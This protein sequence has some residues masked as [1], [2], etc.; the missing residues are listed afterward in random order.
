MFPQRYNPQMMVE[1]YAGDT[2]SSLWLEYY[3]LA[4][5]A[6]GTNDDLAII[7]QLPLYLAESVRAWLENLLEDQIYGWATL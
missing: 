5:Q 2:N 7:H 4:C 3:R 6:D 1:K